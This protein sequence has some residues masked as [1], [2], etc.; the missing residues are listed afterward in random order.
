[1]EGVTLRFFSDEKVSKYALNN[2]CS[3]NQKVDTIMEFHS[4]L[5]NSLIQNAGST[6]KHMNVLFDHIKQKKHFERK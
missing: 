5:S 4:H 3:Y 6:H 2:E 1:M